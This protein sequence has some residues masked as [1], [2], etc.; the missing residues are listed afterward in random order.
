MDV[1]LVSKVRPTLAAVVDKTEALTVT[2][3]VLEVL[4]LAP[5]EG[6]GLAGVV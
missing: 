3:P 4:G 5:M 6:S 1:A 2:E